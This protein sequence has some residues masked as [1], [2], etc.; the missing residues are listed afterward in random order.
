MSEISEYIER[1]SKY[2]NIDEQLKDC[3]LMILA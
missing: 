1:Y 2:A 3:K